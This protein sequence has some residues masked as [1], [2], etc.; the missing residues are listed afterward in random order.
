MNNLQ[1]FGSGRRPE[2]ASTI[3][4]QVAKNFLLSADQTIDRKIKEAILS[5]RIEQ[6]YS[7]DKILELYLNEIFFGQNAYGIA[8]AALTYFDKPVTELTIAET[9]YMPRCRKARPITIP[10]VMSRLPLSAAMGHRPH[11]GERLHHHQ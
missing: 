1:N 4:Q 7:K 8:S 3:T 9:A 10:S 5:F 11:G 2:G 6:T